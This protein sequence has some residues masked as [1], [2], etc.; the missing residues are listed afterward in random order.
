MVT[1][2]GLPHA[3]DAQMQLAHY[4][5]G[6]LRYRL[7]RDPKPGYLRRWLCSFG[8]VFGSPMARPFGGAGQLS[9]AW[10]LSGGAPVP[11]AA[12]TPKGK[13]TLVLSYV[14]DANPGSNDA[15]PGV[16]PTFATATGWTFNGSTQY[17]KTGIIPNAMFSMLIRFSSVAN[18][19][20]L[21]GAL[22]ISPA[23]VRF[24]IFPN[25]TS[26]INYGYG[27]SNNVRSAGVT[28]GVLG[29]AGAH[30][31]RN[32]SQDGADLSAFG[33]NALGNDI[34]IGCRNPAFGEYIT[35]NIQALVICASTYTAPQV[36]AI[37]TALALI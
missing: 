23:I 5:I 34:N 6:R 18:N 36:A 30:G 31:Y 17:L 14:N 28:N 27:A 32:G 22:T 3:T 13:A 10:Y 15:A 37:S 20:C 7:V 35:A 29:I 12:Y 21:I 19:G 1:T 8:G 9:L 26:T 25:S 11:L 2:L 16:A 4:L 33:A 24:N